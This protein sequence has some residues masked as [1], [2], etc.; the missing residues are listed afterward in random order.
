MNGILIVDKPEGLSSAQ[1]VARV[2][3]LLNAARV[4]H[5]GTL[6]PFAR[7]VL[8]CCINRATRLA[9]YL[10]HD[11]KTYDAVMTL[12]VET[13]TQDL[14]GSVIGH[15]DW[16]GVTADRLEQV[17]P[18]FEGTLAQSPPV[19]SALKHGGVPL[20]AL[21]RRGA[22]VQKPPRAVRI[23]RLRLLEVRL[24]QVRL[25][26]RCSAGTYVRSLCA[27]IGRALG[28]G[29]HV[30]ELTRTES[31]GFSIEQALSL[32]EVESVARQGAIGERLIPMARALPGWPVV[33]ADPPLI[34]KIRHGRTLAWAEVSADRRDPAGDALLKVVDG[35]G[36]LVAVLR[37]A[38]SERRLEYG[39]V[40]GPGG[41]G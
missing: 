1:T 30:S 7:G 15:G 9:Q 24:P 39:C 29:A 18:G 19:F 22:P 40:V 31:G 21:A 26:V 23:E 13:D 41:R 32:A 37:Y 28:C 25:E 34:E 5:A 38:A 27:D 14:T 2:K 36:D 17:L 35:S 20:Y 3:H 6:D 12:G 10:L 33:T 4:G 16:S 11:A 8:V